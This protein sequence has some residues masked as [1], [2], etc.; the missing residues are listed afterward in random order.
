MSAFP[1][2][3]D[4]P[5]PATPAKRSY[6]V[7]MVTD[8]P[9]MELSRTIKANYFRCDDGLVSFWDDGEPRDTLHIAYPLSRIKSIQEVTP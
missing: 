3:P 6:A 9:D 7:E 5:K 1:G 4:T 2:K 8:D